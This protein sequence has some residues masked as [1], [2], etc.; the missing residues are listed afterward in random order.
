MRAKIFVQHLT[1]EEELINLI[2]KLSAIAGLNHIRVNPKEESISFEYK[3]D[4]AM[5][6][7]FEGVFQ[8]I[9]SPKI[10]TA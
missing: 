6:L 4:E 10:E 3:N 1:W 9:F 8:D 7:V 2:N 5:L